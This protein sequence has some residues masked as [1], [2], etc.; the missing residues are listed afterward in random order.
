MWWSD[1]QM[2]NDIA[3]GAITEALGVLREPLSMEKHWQS[4]AGIID[5]AGA[6]DGATAADI[7]QDKQDAQEWI[8]GAVELGFDTQ[9][10][11]QVALNQISGCIYR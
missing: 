9:K 8:E 5:E 6:D 11:A 7:A 2:R 4:I 10:A 1:D 3:Y